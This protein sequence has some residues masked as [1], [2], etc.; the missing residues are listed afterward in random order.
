MNKYITNTV[1]LTLTLAGTVTFV[2]IVQ[3]AKNKPIQ[4][5]VQ[6]L[7]NNELEESYQ[8]RKEEEYDEANR[9]I[10]EETDTR[11]R[12]PDLST[13]IENNNKAKIPRPRF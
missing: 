10:R 11:N 4:E 5:T 7:R 8:Q 9:K 12:N 3:D 13:T 6:E 2:N 1:I